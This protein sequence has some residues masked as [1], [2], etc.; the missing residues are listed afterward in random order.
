MTIAFCRAD[1]ASQ[2][3][4]HDGEWRANEAKVGEEGRRRFAYGSSDYWDRKLRRT[5]GLAQTKLLI[6]SALAHDDE[7]K[8]GDKG[9]GEKLDFKFYDRALVELAEGWSSRKQPQSLV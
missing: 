3:K 4:R 8:S 1:A 6:A 9:W 7:G 2:N 5:E